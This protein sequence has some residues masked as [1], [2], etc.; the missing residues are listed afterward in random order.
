MTLSRIQQLEGLGF[1]WAPRT[2]KRPAE[3]GNQKD[4]KRRKETG[5]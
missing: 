4:G 3:T 5:P 1:E 2:A